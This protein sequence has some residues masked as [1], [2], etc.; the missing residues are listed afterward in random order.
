M[1]RSER[2]D[3]RPVLVIGREVR[4]HPERVSEESLR[5][6][7]A[8][9]DAAGGAPA[10]LQVPALAKLH[11]GGETV[12]F[13]GYD[14]A[15]SDE[16]RERVDR[17]DGVSSI[18][19]VRGLDEDLEQAADLGRDEAEEGDEDH[20][21]LGGGRA[22]AGGDEVGERDE[23][24]EAGGGMVEGIGVPCPS[25]SS[26]TAARSLKLNSAMAARSRGPSS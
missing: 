20:L 23:A 18:D 7:L 9:V 22:T 14:L 6:H 19:P 15:R 10:L 2:H 25:E 26:S 5:G 11:R 24:G 8:E 1:G 17:D 16:P 12:G 3:A 4:V 21:A 13:A